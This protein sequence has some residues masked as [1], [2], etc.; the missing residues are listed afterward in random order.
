MR[1]H[2]KKEI[3]F[4]LEQAFSIHS[5]EYIDSGR[6]GKLKHSVA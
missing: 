5:F 6:E 2:S 1:N 3:L 4:G